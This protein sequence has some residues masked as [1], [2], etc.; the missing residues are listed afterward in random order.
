MGLRTAIRDAGPL[1]VFFF[2]VATPMAAI[3]VWWFLEASEFV[4]PNIVFPVSG[5][6]VVISGLG[7]ALLAVD[8]SVLKKALQPS[9]HKPVGGLSASVVGFI[10]SIIYAWVFVFA[11]F[12]VG[13]E[14]EAI[15][16]GGGSYLRLIHNTLGATI[17]LAIPALIIAKFVH[18]ERWLTSL[19]EQGKRDFD[20]ARARVRRIGFWWFFWGCVMQAIATIT[21]NGAPLIPE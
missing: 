1:K 17:L 9:E 15:I 4:V 3:K 2:T 19:F 20:G 5:L 16:K 14:V 12:N 11:F 18:A 8:D 10:A 6:G 7:G 21:V 13:A